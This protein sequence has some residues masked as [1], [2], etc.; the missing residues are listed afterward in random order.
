MS[1]AVELQ[2]SH[3]HTIDH[4]VEVAVSW[5][6]PSGCRLCHSDTHQAQQALFLGHAPGRPSSQ[7]AFKFLEGMTCRSCHR[8]PDAT[9]QATDPEHLSAAVSTSSSCSACHRPEYASIPAWWS[10]GGEQRVRL[11]GRYVSDAERMLGANPPDTV[12][13]L[14]GLARSAVDLVGDGGIAHNIE[15]GDR[16]LRESLDHV[17][18][19]YRLSAEYPPAPPDLGIRARRWFCSS[20]HY[21]LGQPTITSNMPREPHEELR[22]KLEREWS[23]PTIPES[24]FMPP[25]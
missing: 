23:D 9:R 16:L 21:P 12:R 7:P 2:C 8:S 14:L 13:V 20:C 10:R 25:S 5:D 4:F 15:L 6:G 22:R 17:G 1:S 18:L 19:A 11:V 3:C 24:P